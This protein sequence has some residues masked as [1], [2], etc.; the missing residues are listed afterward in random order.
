MEANNNTY[1]ISKSQARLAGIAG[2]IAGDWNAMADALVAVGLRSDGIPAG[3][4][5][6]TAANLDAAALMVA[7]KLAPV[8][9]QVR[10]D[11]DRVDGYDGW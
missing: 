10:D 1:P 3:G 2:V 4:T 8:A 11:G 7:C 9:A 5:W 6:R